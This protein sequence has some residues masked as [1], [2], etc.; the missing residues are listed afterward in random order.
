MGHHKAAQEEKKIN[1]KIASTDKR[2]DLGYPSLRQI[3]DIEMKKHN[4]DRSDTT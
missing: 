1:R 4:C 3:K 2:Y